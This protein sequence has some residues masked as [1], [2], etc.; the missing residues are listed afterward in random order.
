MQKTCRECSADFQITAEDLAFLDKIAPVIAG[1][2]FE[3]SQPT[4]CPDCRQQRRHAWR[5]ERKLYHRNCDATGEPLISMYGQN[6]PH[7][8]YKI[9]V[10][11]GDSWDELSYGRD[12]DFSRPFFEQ[13]KALQLAVPR[14][15]LSAMHNEN[16]PYVN[17]SGYNKNC[18][19]IFAAEYNEDCMYGTQV[20]KSKNC[21]DTLNCYESESCYEVFDCEKCYGLFFSKNCSNC[22]DSWFLE[23]CKGCSNCLCCMNL[24]NKNNCFFNEQLTP[25]EFTARKK[26]FLARVNSEGVEKI[27]DEFREFTHKFP[28]R[29]ATI[30]NCEHVE[31]DYL[32]NSKNLKHCFDLSY[33]EDCAYVYTGFTIKDLRD[34]CHTTEAE[35]GYEGLSFGFGAYGCLFTHG[36]W[37]SRNSL[38]CDIVQNCA[39]CFGCVCV[40]QKKHCILNKKYSKEEYEALVPKI[41]EHMKKDGEWGEFFPMHCSPFAYNETLAQEYYPLS[42]KDV[43]KKKWLWREEKDEIPQVS[44]KIEASAVPRDIKDVPDDILN[45]AID[46]SITKRPYKIIKQEL[47]FYRKMLL[48]VPRIHPEERHRRRMSERN[49]RKLWNR[50]CDNCSREIQT[51]FAPDRPEKIYCEECYLKE[52]Y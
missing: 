26:D 24:R 33:A 3:V 25:E 19:L 23:D 35:M 36:S 29:A 14:L 1:R 8:I 48:P 7:V 16:A 34:I 27:R 12:F 4:R 6:N 52:V 45:W 15:A 9:D 22:S 20:I 32:Q 39:D 40:K 2:K 10:W 17:H 49:P 38:Y 42:K 41:I 37:S 18:H 31:G 30:V 50:T 51:T 5:N 43:E 44:K 46:C 11:Q 28:H 47:D 13:F 21:V